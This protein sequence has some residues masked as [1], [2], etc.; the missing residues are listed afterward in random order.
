MIYS[1]IIL[2]LIGSKLILWKRSLLRRNIGWNL[3]KINI[4]SPLLKI[5]PLLLTTLSRYLGTPSMTMSSPTTSPTTNKTKKEY[6]SPQSHST[7]STPC[8]SNG[9]SKNSSSKTKTTSSQEDNATSQASSATSKD[10]RKNNKMPNWKDNSR[11]T[12]KTQCLKWWAESEKIRI[13]GKMR[14]FWEGRRWK[15]RKERR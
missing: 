3:R 6:L 2:R 8:L 5:S 11:Q 13:C 14:V 15:R 10:N 4:C 1:I 7:L 9:S 12:K